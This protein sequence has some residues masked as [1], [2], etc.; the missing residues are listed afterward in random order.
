MRLQNPWIGYIERTYDDYKAKI[1]E[2]I[3][4]SN[5]EITDLRETNILV[6]IISILAGLSEQL[7]FY[8]DKNAKESYLST[9]EKFSSV[10]KLVKIL[11][12]RIKSRLPAN[13]DLYF[14]FVNTDGTA[15]PIQE[16]GVI[17]AGTVISTEDGMIFITEET[18]TVPIGVSTAKVAAK[19]WELSQ[20]NVLGTTN[21]LANQLIELPENYSHNSLTLSIGGVP[22]ERVQSL[23]TS[24]PGD[25]HYI[26]D[27]GEDRLPRVMFGNGINGAIPTAN[28]SIT[29]TYYITEGS[30]GNEVP[31][32]AISRIES[33]LVLPQPASR[34]TVRNISTPVAGAEIENIDSIRF[35][36]PLSTKS[37]ERA[38]TAEDFEYLAQR[39][40]GVGKASVVYDC[41]SEIEVFISPINGGIA[42]SNLLNEATAYLNSVK[43]IGTRPIL[44]A[45]GETPITMKLSVTPRFRVD[46]ATLIN[47]I[48]TALL[49]K[50]SIANNQINGRIAVSDILAV[51][52]NMPKV[53]YV[54]LVQLSTMPYAFPLEHDT[55]LNW[56]RETLPGSVSTIVWQIANT[57]LG[58]RLWKDGIFMGVIQADTQYTDPQGIVRFRINAGAMY[59]NAQTWT[60]VTY[61]YNST[62]RLTD[63]TVPLLT[64]ATLEVVI[65]NPG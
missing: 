12:Y 11:D 25:N 33:T 23:A 40:D 28:Q 51:V 55:Q 41:G 34:V 43:V 62:I 27:I 46:K 30:L 1:L 2:R 24:L 54:D 63:N 3:R 61:P 14:T 15:I 6:I 58:F 21:G 10:V 7:G 4:V 18:V 56:A 26:V 39:A 65:N 57:P 36:A 53:D 17:P 64:D 37:V 44:K 52:D 29:G 32:Q 50:F 22:W 19:Q 9:A 20:D 47:E 38:V 48:K 60:F 45:A 59:D 5:P 42:T 8:I 31:V 35:N 16:Q 49:E 13:V